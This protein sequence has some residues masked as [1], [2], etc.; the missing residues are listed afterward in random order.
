[1]PEEAIAAITVIICVS[2]LAVTIW[3]VRW[4]HSRF[5]SVITEFMEAGAARNLEAAY[6]CCSPHS[7]A[8]EEIAG[9]IESSYEVFASYERLSINS[10]NPKSDGGIDSYYVKGDI[11][12][13]GK[14]SLPLEAW[15]AKDNDVWKITGIQIGST[16]KRWSSKKTRIAIGVGALGV[17]LA[18]VGSM[19]GSFISVFVGF[20][21]I[22]SV[23]IW[24]ANNLLKKK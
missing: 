10:Q 1:M 21:V 6:A 17:V 2:T 24:A 12:Y 3:L 19:Y 23:G 5:K 13:T 7:P 15:L 14:Q 11:I 9:V 8:K 20:V 4:W 18:I 22:I 16:V